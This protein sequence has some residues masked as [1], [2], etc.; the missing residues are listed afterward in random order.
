MVGLPIDLQ[1]SPFALITNKKVR[2]TR[3]TLTRWA[4]T[5]KTYRKKHH[6][7]TIKCLSYFYFS[8]RVKPHSLPYDRL[9]TIRILIGNLTSL[10]LSK[11]P[12]T[13]VCID[14]FKFYSYLNLDNIRRRKHSTQ[15]LFYQL[16]KA[17]LFALFIQNG[18]SSQKNIPDRILISVIV[19][20]VFP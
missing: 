5:S 13:P 10:C 6:T 4:N 15:S 17:F 14:T 7:S 8:L 11:Q 18:R 1:N 2:Y 20:S 3:L 12:C 16:L 9:L 19:S